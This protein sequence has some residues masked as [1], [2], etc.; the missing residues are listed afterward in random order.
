[1]LVFFFFAVRNTEL[2]RTITQRPSEI[3]KNTAPPLSNLTTPEKTQRRRWRAAA[4]T[5]LHAL[6]Q[7]LP[8]ASGK[9]PIANL[10]RSTPE[11]A[12]VVTPLQ[13]HISRMKLNH[14]NRRP[15]DSGRG[16]VEPSRYY[17]R[18]PSS[19]RDCIEKKNVLVKNI[20]KISFC[21]QYRKISCL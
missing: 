6:D 11:N 19:E 13:I 7:E 8:R 21:L 9:S 5:P 1:M 14:R 10:E 15:T 4:Q 18:R 3:N 2:Q 20:E 16:E 12:V 17:L